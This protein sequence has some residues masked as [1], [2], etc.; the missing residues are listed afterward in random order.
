[1]RVEGEHLPVR[2]DRIFKEEKDIGQITSVTRS[3]ALGAIIALGLL[4]YGSF[5]A[6][7][8]VQIKSGDSILEAQVVDLPFYKME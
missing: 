2:G 1:M 3:E 4:K 7:T 8:H 6:G 5:D